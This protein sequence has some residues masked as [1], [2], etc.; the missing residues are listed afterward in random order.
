[1]AI[2]KETLARALRAKWSDD[3]LSEYELDSRLDALDE[4]AFP[5]FNE[6]MLSSWGHKS[7][8][9]VLGG[10]EKCPSIHDLGGSIDAYLNY[11]FLQSPQLDWLL[12]DAIV[13]SETNA[14]ANTIGGAKWN[15]EDGSPSI[16][17]FLMRSTWSLICW[18]IWL[19]ISIALYLIHP[20]WLAGWVTLT[21]IA[22]YQKWK[23]AKYKRELLQS[24][25][26]VY[27][28][29]DNIQPS[30]RNVYALMEK[31]R[32]KGAKWPTPLY[33][34]VEKRIRE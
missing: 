30:W 24:M 34:L 10:R 8:F 20:L 11:D 14:T 17:L 26:D 19:A 27:G 22:Q 21:A 28:A 31:S 12:A 3:A 29:L 5:I 18:A 16:P 32:D 6:Y 2:S 4:V 13:F 7:Q 25:A 1:M 33:R 23:A 15:K 9:V